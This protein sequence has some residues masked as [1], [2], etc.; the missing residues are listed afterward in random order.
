MPTLLLIRH[1]ENNFVGKRLAGRLPGVHLNEKGQRQAQTIADLLCKAPIKA[2]YSSPLERAVETAQPLAAALHLPVTQ[3]DS[4]LEVNFGLWQGK[5]IKQLSR[6]KLWKVVQEHPTEMRFP[7]GESFVEA[8][9]RIVD[10]LE[11][12]QSAWTERD[13]IA[14]FS[15]SDSIKLAVAHYLGMPLNAFQR[16]HVDT[17]SITAL[18]LGKGGSYLFN[19][20][21]VQGQSFTPPPEDEH[22][23]KGRKPAGQAQQPEDP[24]GLAETDQGIRRD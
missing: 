12:I 15:H 3:H 10:G 20:N 9:Q 24:A 23:K 1:G 13:L 8:Q 21:F 16:L 14:C 22:K 19:L 6:M 2:I 4:L 7:E 5:T 17:T 18:Y 11:E